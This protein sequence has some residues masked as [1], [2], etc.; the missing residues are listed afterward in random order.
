M[1]DPLVR[2]IGA[3]SSP[4]TGAATVHTQIAGRLQSHLPPGVRLDDV[5][6]SVRGTGRFVGPR[7][8]ARSRV[9]VTTSTPLPAFANADHV[10]PIVF[11][12]RW[13]WTRSPV[14]RW[15]R[16][17]DLLQTVRR[18]SHV[19]TISHAVAD[20]LAALRC[21]PSG[22]YT[23]LDLGPGQFQGMQATPAGEREPSVV[24]I[25]AAPHKRNELAAELL[26]S[27]PA[28]RR[29]GRVTA[30]SVSDATVEALRRHFRPDQLDI[31]SGVDRDELAACFAGARAYVALGTSEGFGFAY[32]EAAHQGCDVIA[33]R[34]RSPS[35]CSATTP[36]C[37]RPGPRPPTISTGP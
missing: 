6:R 35:S 21:L 32:I 8:L 12:V 17:A 1:S 4:V 15:Y 29:D 24:L 31:R 26:G 16:H 20:Q 28:F 14:G 37:S 19:L 7:D 30:I 18:S 33:I 10:V 22:G 5:R 25:G 11:D 36:S 34:R 23:V 2:V 27:I 13:R 9:S 3:H